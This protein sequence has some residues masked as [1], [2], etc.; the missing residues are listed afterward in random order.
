MQGSPGGRA[1]SAGHVSAP[2]GPYTQEATRRTVPCG[3]FFANAPIPFVYRT[4]YALLT[5]FTSVGTY[6]TISSLR[7]AGAVVTPFISSAAPFH[8]FCCASSRSSLT[9]VVRRPPSPYD[10]GRRKRVR[11]PSHTRS[12]AAVH[13]TLRAETDSFSACRALGNGRKG[14]PAACSVNHYAI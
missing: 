12:T 1:L 4:L 7:E 10:D 9:L 13:H 8:A 2:A 14:K 6:F 3:F 11:R 5:P